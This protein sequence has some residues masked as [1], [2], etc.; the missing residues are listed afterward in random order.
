MAATDFAMDRFVDARNGVINHTIF[1]HPDIYQQE[2]E[3]IFSP[4]VALCRSRESDP[5]AR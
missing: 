5:Q 2:L 4:H 1:S 3:Q